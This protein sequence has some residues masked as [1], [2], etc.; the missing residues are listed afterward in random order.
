M[1]NV[2]RKR[3]TYDFKE[4]LEFSMGSRKETDAETIMVLLDGCLEVNANDAEGDDNGI[5]FIAT[6]RGGSKV[7]I[8]VKTRQPGCSKFW[9]NGEGE[10]ELAIEKWSVMPGGTCGIPLHSAK[11]GWTVDESKETDLILYTFDP[12]DSSVAY[13]L[14]FQSLRLAA[15]KMIPLWFA[16]HKVDIQTSQSGGRMWQSQAVFVPASEVIAAIQ[17]T[18]THI[19]S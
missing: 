17:L 1:E 13:L 9:R 19:R 10:P 12:K 11:A 7:A 3:M 4:R 5:D 14:P 2:G 15:R 8:D 18:F 16:R 6:L